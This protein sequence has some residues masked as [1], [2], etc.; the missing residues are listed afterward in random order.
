MKKTALA[1]VLI[2]LAG[3]VYPALAETAFD[4]VIIASDSVPVEA[5]FGAML[6]KLYVRE[7]DMIYAGDPIVDLRATKVFAPCDGTV[8][9]FFAQEGDTLDNVKTIYGGVAYIEPV[10]Q[11]QVAATTEKA[12]S[13]SETKKVHI[14]ETV[15]L[16]CSQDGSHTGPA[17]ISAVGDVNEEGNTEYTL[18]VTGGEFFIGE[19]VDIYRSP[20]LT[21]TTR[22]GRGTVKQQKPVAVDGS[23]SLLKAHV[24]Q[25]DKVRR[26]QLLFETVEG[27]LAGLY[28]SSLRIVSPMDGIV[29]KVGVEPGG[30]VSQEAAV[31]TL[32]PISALEAEVTVPVADINSFKKGQKAIVE[33][34]IGADDVLRYDGEVTGV[35]YIVTG[36][37]RNMNVKAY[38]AF[39]AD[40]NVRVGM[41]VIIY[42][43]RAAENTEPAEPAAPADADEPGAADHD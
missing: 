5:P 30:T 39:T 20:D 27:V 18:E 29:S 31:V 8:A 25:G 7:G 23:G 28:P 35:S 41:P 19:T 26:G 17:I 37:G 22:L 2:L 34:D 24:K 12:Y 32:Y 42:A 38:V 9:A 4:G 43:V 33:L 3:C 10:H 40:D 13:A 6:D 11:Y 36:E 1:L 15:Y 14:G 21:N 16:S